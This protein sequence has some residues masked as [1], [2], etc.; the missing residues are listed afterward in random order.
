MN[1]RPAEKLWK[2]MTSQ[3]V[4]H[5]FK[6]CAARADYLSDLAYK[7][8]TELTKYL[9]AA[10]TGA[11]AGVFLLLKSS[12]GRSWY[13]VSFFTFCVGTF[14]VGVSYFILAS[15]CRQVAEGWAE[16]LNAWGRNEMT[17][18]D[19]DAKNRTQHN[20]WKKTAVRVGLVMS[21]VLLMLGGLTAGC[22][23]WKSPKPE[24]PAQARSNQTALRSDVRAFNEENPHRAHCEAARVG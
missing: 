2:D 15:W 14:C 11:A 5:F 13:L 21:F 17:V 9:F 3:E 6:V 23:L 16:S 19:M 12:P 4:D 8:M 10:N 20:S 18:A 22:A 1:E 7:T 24:P